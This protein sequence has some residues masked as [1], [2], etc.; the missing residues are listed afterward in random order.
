M[1]RRRR[2]AT[3]LTVMTVKQEPKPNETCFKNQPGES[4]PDQRHCVQPA[5]HRAPLVSSRLSDFK[6]AAWCPG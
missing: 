4:L 1:A 2:T 6:Y 3:M 5:Q